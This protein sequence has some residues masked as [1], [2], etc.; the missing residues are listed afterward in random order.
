VIRGRPRAGNRRV[1]TFARDEMNGVLKAT[2]IACMAIGP[3]ITTGAAAQDGSRHGRDHDGARAAQYDAEA[4]HGYRDRRHDSRHDSRH[5]RH[6]RYDR[7]R[8]HDRHAHH[9]RHRHSPR[10]SISF[11][12]GPSYG[13]GGAYY[14]GGYYDGYSHYTPRRYRAPSRYMYPAGYRAYS[15][16]VG[17]HLP[18]GYYA[19]S[20]YVDY[21]A[22][23]L[24]PPPYGYHWVRVDND[25]LLVAIASG[26]VADV[27]SGI[28][29]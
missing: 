2:L 8:G 23:G 17:Q 19:P 12:Y 27:L 16:R 28:F 26:L 7:H 22:Y 15:W 1:P 29:Y 18:R 20:Y 25:I 21:R 3:A 5:D 14:G 13:Y 9:D 4:K 10:Y 24:A 11:G 6:D